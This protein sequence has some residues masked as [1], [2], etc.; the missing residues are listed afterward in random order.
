MPVR[1]V[2]TNKQFQKSVTMY[3]PVFAIASGEM[4]A[5]SSS[6]ETKRVGNRVLVFIKIWLL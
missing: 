3:V 4:I 1:D 6:F 2:R 5:L